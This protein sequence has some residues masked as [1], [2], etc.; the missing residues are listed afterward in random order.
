MGDVTLKPI[1]GCPMGCSGCYETKIFEAN[2]GNPEPYDLDATIKTMLR[3]AKRGVT[4]H[5]GEILLMPVPDLEQ[6]MQ[7]AADA[8]LSLSMQTGGGL[9]N[10]RHIELF[11]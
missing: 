5:G 1:L 7:A 11:K 10:E 6:I 3:E 9:I 8:G 4:L 2:G